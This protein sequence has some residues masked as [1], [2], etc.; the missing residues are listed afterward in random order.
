MNN[1]KNFIKLIKEAQ[2]SSHL[3]DK[4]YQVAV[5]TDINLPLRKWNHKGTVYDKSNL[6]AA[7]KYGDGKLLGNSNPKN[8]KGGIYKFE[9]K[10]VYVGF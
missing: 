6:S 4:P 8:E 5:T 2:I 3:N 10:F 9:K 7:Y 1:V